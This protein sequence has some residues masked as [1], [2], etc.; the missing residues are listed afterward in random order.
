MPVSCKHLAVWR[1]RFP[2]TLEALLGQPNPMARA[3]SAKE[4]AAEGE[5]GRNVEGAESERSGAAWMLRRP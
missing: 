1:A 4:K 5:R 2:P 3:K